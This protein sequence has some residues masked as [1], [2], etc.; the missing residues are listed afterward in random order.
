[1]Y[2][3]SKV[4]RYYQALDLP[5]PTQERAVGGLCFAVQDDDWL[6]SAGPTD[7]P[8]AATQPTVHSIGLIVQ[9][10][11]SQVNRIHYIQKVAD[12][13]SCLGNVNLFHI[14]RLNHC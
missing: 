14:D 8:A 4:F 10:I 1:M 11:I 6:V 5:S 2:T 9:R 7:T 13:I 12:G 3:D